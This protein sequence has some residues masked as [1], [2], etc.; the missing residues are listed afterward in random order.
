[1]A[2]G[3]KT[4]AAF[5]AVSV[6]AGATPAPKSKPEPIYEIWLEADGLP[7]PLLLTRDGSK[8]WANAMVLA[9][10]LDALKKCGVK[11]E[12]WRNGKKCW[13]RNLAFTHF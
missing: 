6:A 3:F 11:P 2:T 9:P 4:G 1:M 12:L 7:E 13:S 10:M 5:G 8:L